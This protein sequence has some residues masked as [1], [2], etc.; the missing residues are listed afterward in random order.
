LLDEDRDHF[1]A[2][3]HLASLFA[4]E[5]PDLLRRSGRCFAGDGAS[6]F[7]LYRRISDHRLEEQ[8]AGIEVPTVVCEASDGSCWSGQAAE[9]ARRLGS[10]ATLVRGRRADDAVAEWLDAAF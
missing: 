3:L 1:E 8:V 10:G 5:L 6:I 2:E 9:V 7:G 4:P